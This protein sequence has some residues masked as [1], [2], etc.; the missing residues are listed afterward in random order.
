MKRITAVV[1]AVVFA[2]ALTL[3]QEMQNHDMNAM[4]PMNAKKDT[5]MMKK[6]MKKSSMKHTS[7][8][9]SSKASNKM[10]KSSKTSSMKS[11]SKTHTRGMKS[12]KKDSTKMSGGMM[13]K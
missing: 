8:M 1:L 12:M 13:K 4:K 9:K 6:S 11:K 7:M 3:A 5:T 2:C 10:M